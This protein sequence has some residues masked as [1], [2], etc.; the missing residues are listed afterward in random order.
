MVAS[1]VFSVLAGFQFILPD[2]FS[3]AQNNV[4]T[5]EK[6]EGTE[7]KKGTVKKIEMIEK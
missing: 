2:L 5:L 1:I 4:M 3:E 7:T 6:E